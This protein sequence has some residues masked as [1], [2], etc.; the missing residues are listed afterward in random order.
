LNRRLGIAALAQACD[1]SLRSERPSR[2]LDGYVEAQVHGGASLDS[3]VEAVVLDPSFR[4]TSIEE[5]LRAAA[6]QY[7]FSLGWHA[8]SELHVDEVPADFRGPTMPALAQVVARPDGVIDAHAI[9]VRAANVRFAEPT[10]AGDPH[11][12]DLQQLKY[13]WHTVLAHGH[14]ADPV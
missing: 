12:S 11:D 4:G 14:D 2:D 7:D 3:D 10:L 9:G 1:G 13:L 6:E 5:D 8:G